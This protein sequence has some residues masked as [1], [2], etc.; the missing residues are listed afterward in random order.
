LFDEVIIINDDKQI[1]PTMKSIKMNQPNAKLLF[2]ENDGEFRKSYCFNMAAE[3]ATGD[4]LC[5]YD[6][7]VLVP[8]DQLKDAFNIISNGCADHV[9]P[10]NGI[11]IDVKK[12]F[13][14]YFMS[15]E[16]INMEVLRNEVTSTKLGFFNGNINVIS[17]NSPGGCNVISRKAF[18]RIGGYDDS[19]IGWGFEDT[20]FLERSKKK[21]AV[22]Y[23]GFKEK[24]LFHLE[25][26]SHCDQDRSKQ[27]HYRDNH[28]RFIQNAQG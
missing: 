21:N 10:F 23:L 13:F 3:I 28:N 11:F 19:F 18:D 14:D 6:V 9:Y 17:D 20:D 24:Y 25:H 5:F 27:P 16:G 4:I 2:C 7:D 22:T 26:S 1:D 8:W 15:E 12:R